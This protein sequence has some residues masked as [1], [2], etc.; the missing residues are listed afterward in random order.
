MSASAAAD[1]STAATWASSSAACSTEPSHSYQASSPGR[2]GISA[3]TSGSCPK[4]APGS[5]HCVSC[6]P[7]VASPAGKTGA[8][9][10]SVVCGSPVYWS[11]G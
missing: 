5:T 10:Q 9:D 8:L 2:A 7:P 3:M 11:K 1:R 6:S 4:N